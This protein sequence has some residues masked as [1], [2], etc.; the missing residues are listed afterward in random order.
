MAQEGGVILDGR[1]I[2]TVVLPQADL[3]I[4]LTLLSIPGPAAAT[5]KSRPRAAAKSMK[6]SLPASLPATIW[7]RTGPCRR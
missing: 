1:D 7:T 6:T 2:G 5:W 3:K 4:F